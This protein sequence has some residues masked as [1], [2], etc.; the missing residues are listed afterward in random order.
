MTTSQPYSEAE[1][2]SQCPPEFAAVMSCAGPNATFSC[3]AMGGPYPDGCQ[4][5][6]DELMQCMPMP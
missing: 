2:L 4:T 1:A 3:D 5:E 6:Q